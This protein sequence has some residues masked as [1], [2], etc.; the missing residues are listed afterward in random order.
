[1]CGGLLSVCAGLVAAADTVLSCSTTPGTLTP[2]P[3]TD[4]NDGTEANSG[5]EPVVPGILD[6]SSFASDSFVHDTGRC[7]QSSST[8]QL[9]PLSEYRSSVCRGWIGEN[10]IEEQTPSAPI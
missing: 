4:M 10:A 8:A 5:P 6:L 3:K 9:F 7:P 2:F 1:M